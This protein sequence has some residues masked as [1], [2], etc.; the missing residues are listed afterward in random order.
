MIEAEYKAQ[1]IKNLNNNS[2]DSNNVQ[3]NNNSESLE[4]SV[5][6]EEESDDIK[7]KNKANSENIENKIVNKETEETPKKKKKKSQQASDI[8]CNE[9]EN[10]LEENIKPPLETKTKR[11]LQDKVNE[12]SLNVKIKNT[13]D[14]QPDL[15]KKSKKKS[16]IEATE[17]DDIIKN[18]ISNIENESQNIDVTIGENELLSEKKKKRKKEKMLLVNVTENDL[19]VK[20]K[21][22]IDIQPDLV[23]KSKKKSKVKDVESNDTIENGSQNNRIINEEDGILVETS[24]KKS[25]KKCKV[26]GSESNGT[27][28][29]DISNVENES[30]NN[31]T[32]NGENEILV[33]TSEVQLSKKKKKELKKEMKYQQELASITNC[34]TEVNKKPVSKKKKRELNDNNENEEPQQKILKTGNILLTFKNNNL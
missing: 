34:V 12:D 15:L 22:T 25:G 21:N 33:E 16:K 11:K 18:D 28:E 31:R 14:V 24:V 3:E 17:S 10:Q 7:E 13:I 26:K 29:K 4:K 9:T 6:V 30:Q 1:Q 23:K 32:I 5:I 2:T 19:N 20:I 27:I 8:K